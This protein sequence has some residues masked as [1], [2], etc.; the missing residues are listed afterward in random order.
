[1][2]P[3]AISESPQIPSPFNLQKQLHSHAHPSP[4]WHLL[5]APQTPCRDP[6]PPFIDSASRAGGFRAPRGHS[7][8]WGS[9][10]PFENVFF[11]K[12]LLWEGVPPP[13]SQLQATRGCVGSQCDVAELCVVTGG[14]RCWW[15]PP[16]VKT[17]DTPSARGRDPA[18]LLAPCQAGRAPQHL[19]A[20]RRRRAPG[21]VVPR[22]PQG[23]GHRLH[24]GLRSRALWTPGPA[25]R[26]CFSLSG[27]W[28]PA[29]C[30]QQGQ[31]VKA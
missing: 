12:M 6:L 26:F 11:L 14:L 3:P 22:F 15:V 2:P 21:S 13:R 1:M 7:G 9:L 19:P 20:V 29:R 4:Q 25:G 24:S 5:C 18:D 8:P 23:A 17:S 27:S 16:V 31:G 30:L 10:F 28:A